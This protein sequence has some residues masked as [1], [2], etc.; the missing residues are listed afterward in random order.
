MA[1]SSEAR[2]EDPY[3]TVFHTVELKGARALE[4]MCG[5]MYAEPLM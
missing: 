1:A 2:R 5:S 3:D 4:A